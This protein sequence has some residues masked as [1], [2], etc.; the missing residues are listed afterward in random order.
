M[1][2]N[3]VK[4]V[5]VSTWKVNMLQYFYTLCKKLNFSLH[6]FHC[7]YY[8]FFICGEYTVSKIAACI[9]YV[10]F[11][12]RTSNQAETMSFTKRIFN[13]H[14]FE[15]MWQKSS[16]RKSLKTLICIMFYYSILDKGEWDAN[17]FHHTGIWAEIHSK[18]FNLRTAI[19]SFQFG[20]NSFVEQNA[21]LSAVCR[22]L[23]VL[24]VHV[25]ISCAVEMYSKGY[26]IERRNDFTQ[27]VAKKNS[28]VYFFFCSAYFYQRFWG[29]Y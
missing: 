9:T 15:N 20:N 1:W 6:F 29:G 10:P 27:F 24:Y 17:S 28:F 26:I 5:I 13:F 11:E 16:F 12:I 18:V 19:R 23:D 3:Y 7:P 25:F 2:P 22:I 8:I 4:D 21:S 14:P